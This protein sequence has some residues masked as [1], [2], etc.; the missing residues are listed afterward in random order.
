M[1]RR[2]GRGGVHTDA[3]N[4]PM[5]PHPRSRCP[6]PQHAV[7]VGGAGL[8]P[9]R[10]A[11]RRHDG[12]H[13]RRA[14]A[15]RHR[16][17]RPGGAGDGRPEERPSLEEESAERRTTRTGSAVGRDGPGVL[18]SRDVGRAGT[19]LLQD[20]RRPP[21]PLRRRHRRPPRLP[22][23]HGSVSRCSCGG[24]VGALLLV[25]RRRP[26]DRCGRRRR[27]ARGEADHRT[28]HQRASAAAWA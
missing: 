4:A 28:G 16:A 21:C 3:R 2:A 22:G 19:G 9:L 24:L 5:R 6:S 25:M 17:V 1:Q 20:S 14:G 10:D 12:G 26:A 8:E 15:G 23:R 11:A 18:G 7:G 13:Q 27:E